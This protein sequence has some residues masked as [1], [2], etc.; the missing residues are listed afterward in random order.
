MGLGRFGPKCDVF[1]LGVILYELLAGAYPFKA[2]VLTAEVFTKLHRRGPDW[3]R[4]SSSKHGKALC[5][6]MLTF[7]E[8]DR[9]TMRECREHRWFET[10]MQQL[11]RVPAVQFEPFANFC[12]QQ[13]VKRSLLLEIAARLP[14]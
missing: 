13:H 1:S 4:V 8:A 6:A 2:K 5:R 10:E 14:V 12:K 9:P 3:S 7:S 11:K